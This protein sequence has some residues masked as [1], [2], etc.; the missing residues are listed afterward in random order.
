[1]LNRDRVEGSARRR[2]AESSTPACTRR[3]ATRRGCG[4]IGAGEVREPVGETRVG[5][6]RRAL[7]IACSGGA[8]RE[9]SVCGDGSDP[10]GGGGPDGS[11]AAGARPGCGARQSPAPGRQ[12]ALRSPPGGRDWRSRPARSACPPRRRSRAVA[13]PRRAA[14]YPASRPQPRRSPARPPSS[15]AYDAILFLDVV[16]AAEDTLLADSAWAFRKGPGAK[17]PGPR[18]VPSNCSVAQL[19]AVDPHRRV[20]INLGGAG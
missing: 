8:C 17:A 11:G 5:E 20:W 9:I 4:R 12:A 14:R 3:D 18:L 1:M 19:P 13:D 15:C 10:T 16:L 7:G 6:S 2:T